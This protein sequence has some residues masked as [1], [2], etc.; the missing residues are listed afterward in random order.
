MTPE[1]ITGI[2]TAAYADLF[3]RMRSGFALDEVDRP[4]VSEQLTW[5]AE[6]PDFVQ[7]SFE[8]AELYLYHIVSQLEARRMPAE[9]ALLPVIESAYQPYALSRTRALGLWQ[10]MAGTANRF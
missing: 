1:P 3:A 8:S 10:F 5:F 4:A 2:D 9:L 7:H 6:N